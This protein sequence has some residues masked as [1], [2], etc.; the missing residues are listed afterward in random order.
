MTGAQIGHYRITTPL[1]K[2]GMGDVFRARDLNLGREVAVKILP[3]PYAADPDRRGRF[4]REAQA[5]SALSHPNIATIYEA[6][7]DNGIVYIAMELVD[8]ERFR[9]LMTGRCRLLASRTRPSGSC[10]SRQST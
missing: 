3:A 1:G 8:G 4:Q 10:R 5:A 9:D 2:G 7:V 6:G